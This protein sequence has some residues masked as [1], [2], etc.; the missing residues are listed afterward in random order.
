MPMEHVHGLTY[1]NDEYVRAHPG[2]KRRA[3]VGLSIGDVAPLLSSTLNGSERM[4]LEWHVANTV[5]ALVF[6]AINYANCSNRLYMRQC[7]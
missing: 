4:S 1:R 7:I 6:A 3:F 5:G 2:A